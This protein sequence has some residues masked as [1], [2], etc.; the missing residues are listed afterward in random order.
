VAKHYIKT[1][2]NKHFRTEKIL[3]LEHFQTGTNLEHV[4]ATAHASAMACMLA[5]LLRSDSMCAVDANTTAGNFP[6]I[7]LGLAF[8]V[9]QKMDQITGWG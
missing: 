5:R 1:I 2:Q 8:C 4:H 3:K 6:S 9:S 7:L